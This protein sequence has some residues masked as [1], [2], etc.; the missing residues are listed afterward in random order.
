M[1]SGSDGVLYGRGEQGGAQ[2]AGDAGRAGDEVDGQPGDGVPQRLHRVGGEPLAGPAPGAGRGAGGGG[3]AA[4]ARDTPATGCR[5]RR[6]RRRVRAGLVTVTGLAGRIWVGAVQGEAGR[7]QRQADDLVHHPHVRVPGHHRFGD[8]VT[9]GRLGVL[10]G[11]VA[12]LARRA[13]QPDLL[14][15]RRAG[16]LAQLRE[17]D[18]HRH[19]GVRARPGPAPSSRRSAAHS[20]P[21]AR[22]GTAAPRSGD[23]R[24]RPSCPA[25]PAPPAPRR[26]IPG[27]GSRGARPRRR[28][29][30]RPARTGRRTRPHRRPAA[31]RA[32]APA[33]RRRSSA[34][35]PATPRPER[36]APG[37]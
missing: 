33:R 26:R 22:R 17:R 24:R 35:H 20:R 8:R 15:L 32:T 30:S 4:R 7:G 11:Q 28:T 1:S 6:R 25:P 16:T 29:W 12:R 37:S 5:H 23:P 2:P 9:R 14:G 36:P 18:M 3:S 31:T 34:G 10:A 13:A 21:A 27:S 19:V